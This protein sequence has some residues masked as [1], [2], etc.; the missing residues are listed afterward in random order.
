MTTLPVSPRQRQP[1]PTRPRRR[2]PR[3]PQPRGPR[4]TPGCSA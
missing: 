1:R 2:C 3:A 4:R